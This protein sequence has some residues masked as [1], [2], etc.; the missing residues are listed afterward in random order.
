MRNKNT[1]FRRIHTKKRYKTASVAF[2]GVVIGTGYAFAAIRGIET[3]REISSAPSSFV[4]VQEAKAETLDEVLVDDP[5]DSK[6]SLPKA[7]TKNG[8]VATYEK[9]DEIIRKEFPAG[10]VSHAR[11]VIWCESRYDASAHNKNP[12]TGDDSVGLAQINLIGNL[13]QG[14]LT[15]AQFL[16]YSGEPTREALTEW[17]KIPENNIR[18]FSSM[19]ETNG[20]SAWSCDAKVKD[21]TWK[22]RDEMISFL[23][24]GTVSEKMPI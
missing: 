16:G 12:A 10:D 13:F 2:L 1:R 22:Y 14:R 19:K 9:I 20:W 15:R 23:G 6:A 17:L 24:E 11:R 3:F 18:Y 7:T 5:A 21:P 8:N 4:F